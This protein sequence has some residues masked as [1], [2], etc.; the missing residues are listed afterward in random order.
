[1]SIFDPHSHWAINPLVNNGGASSISGLEDYAAHTNLGKAGKFSKQIMG[2][3]MGGDF[4]NL[5]GTLLSPIHDQYATQ[6]REALRGNSMGGNA[7][8]Q[9]SQPALM[10]NIEQDTR[11]KM[12]EGEGMA[13]GQ[14]IPQLW[15]Q[16]SSTYQNALNNRNQ[17]QLQALQTAMQARQNGAQFYQTPSTFSNIMSSAS[18]LGSILGM[19]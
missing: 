10:A 3:M 18:G 7:F 17:T 2:Q 6:M 13:Y 1:M 8:A 4:S 12:A 11:R 5:A 14:A 19:I 15:N 16:A 9:G